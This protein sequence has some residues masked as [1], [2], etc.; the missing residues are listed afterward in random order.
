MK[1][2]QYNYT[3]ACYSQ[4]VVGIDRRLL[5]FTGCQPSWHSVRDPESKEQERMVK[6][7]TWHPPLASIYTG[8]FACSQTCT[9]HI[10]HPPHTHTHTHTKREKGY[11]HKNH[12]DFICFITNNN[13]KLREINKLAGSGHGN[14][15]LWSRKILEERRQIALQVSPLKWQLRKAEFYSGILLWI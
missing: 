9:H 7:N 15:C 2:I 11:M 1:K 8:L 13:S 4:T 10:Y 3:H 5:R 6:Q 14:T 12:E